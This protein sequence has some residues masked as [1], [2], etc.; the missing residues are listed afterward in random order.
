LKGG[1]TG[2]DCF[3]SS[4]H[5]SKSEFAIHKL[6]VTRCVKTGARSKC[7]SHNC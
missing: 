2:E 6:I 4:Q 3:A 7:V 5:S 1:K